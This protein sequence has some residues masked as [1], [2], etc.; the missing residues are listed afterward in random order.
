[1]LFQAAEESLTYARFL[2]DLTSPFDDISWGSAYATGTRVWVRRGEVWRAFL[3]SDLTAPAKAS[4]THLHLNQFTQIKGLAGT[5]TSS[6]TY[7]DLSGGGVT[8]ATLPTF[9]GGTLAEFLC[10]GSII[11]NQ[12]VAA[13]TYDLRIGESSPGTS[14]NTFVGLNNVD[15]I[16]VCVN[17]VVRLV[18]PVAPLTFQIQGEVSLGANVLTIGGGF[19]AVVLLET[20]APLS[21]S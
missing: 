2:A 1:M 21:G 4:S 3:I 13:D 12:S 9:P 15:N 5:S 20:Q 10:V 11:A 18:S 6:V 14:F 7:V 17:T 8:F 16:P 19:L